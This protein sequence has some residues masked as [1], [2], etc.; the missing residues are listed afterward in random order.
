MQSFKLQSQHQ[1]PSHEGRGKMSSV[2]AKPTFEQPEYIEE[3]ISSIYDMLDKY[4]Q[5]SMCDKI[6]HGLFY[7][8][9]LYNEHL[10]RT[11]G[12]MCGHKNHYKLVGSVIDSNICKVFI[13]FETKDMF[14]NITEIHVQRAHSFIEWFLSILGTLQS[15]TSIAA[16]AINILGAANTLSNNAGSFSTSGIAGADTQGIVVGT[17]TTANTPTTYQLA[18]IIPVGVATGELSYAA[19]AFL[20][21]IV[22][23]NNVSFVTSRQFSNT[24][25]ASITIN[26]VGEY[27][28]CYSSTLASFTYFL[29]IRDVLTSP[30]TVANSS[31]TTATYSIQITVS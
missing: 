26:E 23:G 14:G 1:C 15:S 24:S 27:A 25:G 20:A 28:S 17:G 6:S 7:N 18:T 22:S 4:Y 19:D 29:M 10:I 11:L 16:S 5:C 30:I 13:T 8:Q 12:L 31:T 2:I 3:D 9:K 21:P